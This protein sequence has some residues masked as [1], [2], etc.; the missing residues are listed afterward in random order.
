MPV[1]QVQSE[2]AAVP[3]QQD[4]GQVAVLRAELAQKEESM[5]QLAQQAQAGQL[6]DAMFRQVRDVYVGQRKHLRQQVEDCKGAGP[7]ANLACLKQTM[8]LFDSHFDMA[9]TQDVGKGGSTAGLEC[10]QKMLK[11]RKVRISWKF[12]TRTR[13]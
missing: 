3:V 5:Q 1:E 12:Q 13:L 11:V 4:D 6:A 7:I 10:V 2:P 9:G 8:E